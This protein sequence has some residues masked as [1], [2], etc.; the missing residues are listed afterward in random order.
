M[1]FSVAQVTAGTG[2]S[3]ATMWLSSPEWL[4]WRAP[5]LVWY[6]VPPYLFSDQP[7]TQQA[8]RLGNSVKYIGTPHSVLS[9]LGV[10][11][12]GSRVALTSQLAGSKHG[13]TIRFAGLI[14][15]T[16]RF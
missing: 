6:T 5:A 7:L 14:C 13:S 12:V 16:E 3:L 9:M 2:A 15:N 10:Y 1:R 8:Y 4:T 11:T